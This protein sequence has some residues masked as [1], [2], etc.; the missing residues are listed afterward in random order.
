MKILK[1]TL[2]VIKLHGKDQYINNLQLSTVS[3]GKFLLFLFLKNIGKYWPKDLNAVSE[4]GPFRITKKGLTEGKDFTIVDL[5][6][7]KEG[8][9]E[10][11]VF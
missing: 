6:C 1:K 5:C 3:F 9:N 4:F 10:V 7:H 8:Q 2:W 11:Y